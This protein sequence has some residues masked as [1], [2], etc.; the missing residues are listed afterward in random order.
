MIKIKIKDPL[1]GKNKNSF[2]GFLYMKEYLREYQIDIT[3]SDDYDYLF[4]GANEFYNKGKSLKESIDHGL[5]NT[6]KISGDYFMFDGSDSTALIG[7]YEVFEQSN[8]LFL[9]KNAKLKKRES[10]KKPSPLNKWFFNTGSDLDIGYDIP[11]DKWKNIK[12]TGF[13]LGYLMSSGQYRLSTQKLLAP[14]PSK[15]EDVCAI[16]Q[17]IHSENYE[18]KARNDH[19][20]TNHR[21]GAWNVLADI[22]QK[23]RVHTDKLPYNEYVEV[24]KNSKLAISPYGMG[25]VCYRDFELMEFGTAMIKPNMSD[26]I[27]TPDYYIDEKTYF[28]VKPDWSN[29]N[30]KI[31]YLLD[32]MELVDFVANNAQKR[33]TELYSPHNFCMHWYNFFSNINQVV[34]DE[35]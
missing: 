30:E 17:G 19:F 3:D 9:M 22:K 20:Y 7:A 10:Y 6:S 13:N 2:I 4:I 27:T 26:I 35:T 5:E 34:K 21:K 16:Y 14:K 32:N 24:L 11:E 25:E 29:L 33:F 23:Y 31:E 28:A 8:A 1:V 12:T 15:K 18:H